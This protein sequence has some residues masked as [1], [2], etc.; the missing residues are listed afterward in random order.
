MTNKNL[1]VYNH[2]YNHF[3]EI[4]IT[5]KIILYN[6]GIFTVQIIFHYYILIN[7]TFKMYIENKYLNMTIPKH[8]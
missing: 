8:I 6:L 1:I 3:L 7:C 4:I 5:L 2:I